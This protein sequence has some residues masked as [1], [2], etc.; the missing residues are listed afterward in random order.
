V[1]TDLVNRA[2]VLGE[3]GLLRYDRIRRNLEA[4]N[5]RDVSSRWPGTHVFEPW[6]S[7]VS[8]MERI[9]QK[10]WGP[11]NVVRTRTEFGKPFLV[12]E[13][14]DTDRLRWAVE[15]ENNR[16]TLGIPSASSYA[17]AAFALTVPQAIHLFGE[18]TPRFYR[19]FLS[20][21][22]WI[23]P[24]SHI[25]HEPS[26]RGRG[27]SSHAFRRCI[28]VEPPERNQ[29]KA[30]IVALNLAHETAHQVLQVYQASDSLIEESSLRTPVFSIIRQ[31]DRPAILSFHAVLA[32]VFMAEWAHEALLSPLP[33]TSQRAWLNAQKRENVEA[34][35]TGFRALETIQMT[36]LGREI[37]SEC[38]AF[39]TSIE[40]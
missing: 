24:L 19:K 29:L 2:W 20:S 36:P 15:G 39:M 31:V 8:C 22:L 35:L 37:R 34:S 16:D 6:M 38:L 14:N 25:D 12:L 5:L 32:S 11:G 18:W 40:G 10:G 26:P 13:K 1:T 23:A 28:L 9:A 4:L 17:A 21:C 33:D 30:E 7:S 3:E 27:R